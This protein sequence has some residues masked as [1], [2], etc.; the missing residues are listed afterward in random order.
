MQNDLVYKNY[1]G[2]SCYYLGLACR[3][4]FDLCPHVAVAII[5]IKVGVF[6][7]LVN[8][9]WFYASGKKLLRKCCWIQA[10]NGTIEKTLMPW[11]CDRVCL[12]CRITADE[13][14]Q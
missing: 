13:F 2:S 1:A 12:W 5:T 14:P 8:C 6:F 3:L 4:K 9:E 10:S 11:H 7:K